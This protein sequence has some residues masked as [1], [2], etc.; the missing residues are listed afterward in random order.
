MIEIEN[1]PALRVSRSSSELASLIPSVATRINTSPNARAAEA[2]T[3]TIARAINSE[4]L[5]FD[6][7]SELQNPSLP[8]PRKYKSPNAGE[9][10]M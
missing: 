3:G 10:I 4:I 8:F 1:H 7:S 2:Y 6:P 9:S 5:N